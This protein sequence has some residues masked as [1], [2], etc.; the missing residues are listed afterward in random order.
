MPCEQ[1]GVY[2]VLKRLKETGSALPKVRSTLSRKVRMPKVIKNTKEKIRRNPRKSV[3]KLAS[4]S[5]VSYRT[6]HA[7]LK[8][9]LNL[10]SYKITKAQLLSQATK[11][12]WL[13]RAKLLL[14]NLRDGT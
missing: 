1:S 8:N 9:D 2:K 14:E 12:K 7:V 5:G 11:T 4:A 10:F 3:R 13:Q 6:M